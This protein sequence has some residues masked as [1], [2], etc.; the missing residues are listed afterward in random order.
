LL[1]GFLSSFGFGGFFFSGLGRLPL[2]CIDIVVLLSAVLK[3][4]GNPVLDQ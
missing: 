4:T 1:P 2:S 3:M